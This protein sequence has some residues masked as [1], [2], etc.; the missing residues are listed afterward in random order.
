LECLCGKPMNLTGTCSEPG[1]GLGACTNFLK[2]PKMKVWA[3]PPTGCGR[4]Y[5]EGGN[6]AITGTWYL[7]EQNESRALSS[8]K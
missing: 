8:L 5:L 2:A 6:E 3:C 1:P 4:I 7:P